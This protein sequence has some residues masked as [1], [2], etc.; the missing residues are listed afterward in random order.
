MQDGTVVCTDPFVSA[1]SPDVGGGALPGYQGTN[2]STNTI[3]LETVVD[4]QWS[5]GPWMGIPWAGSVPWSYW[6]WEDGTE[7]VNSWRQ[8]ALCARE[9]PIVDRKEEL[10][11]PGQQTE[12]HKKGSRRSWARNQIGNPDENAFGQGEN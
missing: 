7:D 8:I 12:N 5:T 2:S 3:G 4:N 10:C 11:E 6:D 1:L 9:K